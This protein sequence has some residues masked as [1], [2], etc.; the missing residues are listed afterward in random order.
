M[1]A[2]IG[3]A[4]HQVSHAR[5]AHSSLS[6]P[7][8]GQPSSHLPITTQSLP[9]TPSL[10]VPHSSA[11]VFPIGVKY[12]GLLFSRGSSPALQLRSFTALF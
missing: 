2:T 1:E 8:Q 3:K 10:R 9:R 7:V 11:W 5:L 4:G 12:I 6:L